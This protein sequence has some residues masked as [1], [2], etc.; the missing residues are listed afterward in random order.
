[1]SLKRN[2]L[3]NYLGQGWSAVMQLAFIPL[4]IKYLGME[5]YGL[6]GVYATL[7]AGFLL[8]DMG[9][10]PT[11]NREMARYAAGAHSARS[12]RELLRSLELIFA[13]VAM[14]IICIVWG[15]SDWF[16]LH[17]VKVEKLPLE[18]VS[19]AFAIMGVVAALRL[20]ENVYRGAILG[21][22]TQVWLNAATAIL[23]TFRWLGAVGVLV[24]VSQTIVAFFIW[25]GCISL[26]TVIVFALRVHRVIPAAQQVHF[27]KS[28]VAGV[29][30]FARGMILTMVLALILTHT[31]KI[32]LSRLLSLEAFGAYT[33]AA[34]L[35]GGLMLLVAPLAQGYYPKFTELLTRQDEPGLIR[36][37]HQAAQLMS[38]MVMP[39]ALI[40]MFYGETVLYLWTGDAELARHSA[41]L[42][43]LLTLGTAFL[44]LMNIPYMLQLAYGW[45]VFAA[46][47]NAVVV[48]VLIPVLLWVTPRYGAM[49][50]AWVWLAI[51]SSYVFVVVPLM[52]RRLLSEEKW[53]WYWRDNVLPSVSAA[54]VA[55]AGT[56]IDIAGFSKFGQFLWLGIIGLLAF[57]AAVFS[58]PVLRGNMLRTFKSGM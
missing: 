4:Y 23:A 35:A 46:K 11:L 12:I 3:A 32:L 7:Q 53:T 8:L 54:A 50:A 36:V 48:A 2:I 26:L 16:A 28:A 25:Q 19:D 22:Q 56:W 5:S 55:F 45:S 13:G 41:P 10:A 15:A 27:S 29:W 43:A 18:T 21:L 24:W 33:L 1:M 17:W 58:A 20:V 37:Y 34:T 51:T 38:V 30:E 9:M 47:V 44:G 39:A 52:H 14:L 49:G 42:L 6:I 31:D 57:S 40:L